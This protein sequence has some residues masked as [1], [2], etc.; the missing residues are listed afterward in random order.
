[1]SFICAWGSRSHGAGD[2]IV[3]QGQIGTLEELAAHPVGGVGAPVIVRADE[4]PP[5]PRDAALGRRS[6]WVEDELGHALRQQ[7]RALLALVDD[8]LDGAGLEGG[9]E[10]VE[11]RL[12]AVDEARLRAVQAEAAEVEQR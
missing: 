6:W 9:V 2:E 12:A 4:H 10:H 5:P 7:G 11:G 1:M 8:E 3:Q